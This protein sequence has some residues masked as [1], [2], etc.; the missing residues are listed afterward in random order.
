MQMPVQIGGSPLALGQ[1]PSAFWSLGPPVPNQ[2]KA[3]HTLGS[4]FRKRSI[5]P[6]SDLQSSMAAQPSALYPLDQAQMKPQSLPQGLNTPDFYII[7]AFF[8]ISFPIHLRSSPPVHYEEMGWQWRGCETGK[9]RATSWRRGWLEMQPWTWF[10]AVMLAPSLLPCVRFFLMTQCSK[11]AKHLKLYWN[12][13]INHMSEV[14]LSWADSHVACLDCTLFS[15]LPICLSVQHLEER[16]PE[17]PEVENIKSHRNHT[18]WS[19][20]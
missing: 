8:I 17:T 7:S 18:L 9:G 16:T 1:L 15:Y 10:L 5:S 20:L 19:H 4:P 3:L 2:C 12:L 14:T 13:W 11:S 6:S